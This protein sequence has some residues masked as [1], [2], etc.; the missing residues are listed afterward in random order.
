MKAIDMKPFPELI[1][2]EILERAG[3]F[4]SCNLCDGMKGLASR[5]MGDV[6]R[7][8][9]AGSIHE[10]RGN[11]NDVEAQPGDNL[12]IHVALYTS[13]PGYVMVIDGKACEE[14]PYFGDLM[15]GVARVIG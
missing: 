10:V 14:Y 1:S 2:D 12:P 9:T 7:H 6:C 4:S 8:R 13:Q 3:K 11:G 5:W 15:M